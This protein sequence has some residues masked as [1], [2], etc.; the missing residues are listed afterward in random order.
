MLEIT[1]ENLRWAYVTFEISQDDSVFICW[2]KIEVNLR[3]LAIFRNF[4]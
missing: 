4:A 3:G 2:L 1:P